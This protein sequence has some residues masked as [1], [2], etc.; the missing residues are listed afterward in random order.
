MRNVKW[1]WF[2]RAAQLLILL[3][4]VYLLLG[5]RKDGSTI[6]PF[7]FF[8]IIDPL[9]GISAMVSGRTL[10]LSMLIGG[11][12]ILLLT[13]VF[14]RFWCGWLCPMGTVLDWTRLRRRF[15]RPSVSPS[16][17]QHT[18][19]YI[20]VVILLSAV[21]GSLTLIILDPITLLYRTFASAFLPGVHW[22][23][24]RAE[25]LLYNYQGLEGPLDSF[26]SFYRE[27]IFPVDQSF[28]WPGFLVV[29]LFLAILILN[30]IRPRL[31]C[32]YLCPLGALLGIVSKVSIIRHIL[33]EEKCVSC[34]RCARV[35]LTGAIDS[36]HNYAV[37]TA[38]C[39]ACLRCLETC[40]TKAV[41]FGRWRS[42]AGP[43]PIDPSRR[44]V[45]A[46]IVGIA[47]GT[48]I[49]RTFSVFAKSGDRSI[50]PPGSSE[51][52]IMDSCIRCGECINVCPTGGLQPSLH[53]SSYGALWTP[54]LIP[55]QGECDY[56]CTKCGEVCPTQA[57]K[58]LSLDVKR[59]TKIGTAHINR[60]RCIP[61][62]EARSCIVCE[63]MCPLPEKAIRLE[64]REVING[65]GLATAV[66]LPYVI[67]E[68]CIGCGVCENRCP[69]NG[70][71]AIRVYTTNKPVLD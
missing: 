46:G 47:V 52:S 55:R 32:C 11:T 17:W 31:W 63:E 29:S 2:R 42:T 6:L 25:S 35:C 28:F 4:F 61:W 70:A 65:K 7:D 69:L 19:Y 57:I 5:I 13:L 68:L 20:L 1:R 48:I 39:T 45:L 34:Q 49:L 8:F 36:H 18:K 59:S 40:P 33:D 44:R 26:D 23:I 66:L 9:A 54:V 24:T 10:I 27:N 12:I 21:L 3:L 71:A 56:T 30:A 38:E 58:K 60:E 67:P 14:G 64:N 37:N 43:E 51:K 15:Q 22:V 62:T 53:Q 50:T 16:K 41:S